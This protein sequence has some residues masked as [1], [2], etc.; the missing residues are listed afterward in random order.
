MGEMT[1]TKYL[2]SV[3]I[4]TGLYGADWK[5]VTPEELAQKAPRV[6]KDADAEAF[7]WEVHV[8]DEAQGGEYPHSVFTHYI[9]I[10]IFTDRG[11]EKYGTVDI[12]YFGR[13]NVSGIAARTIKAD[14]SI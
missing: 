4:A 1:V 2:F 13:T 10:K 14:G 7:L 11:K 6:E 3:L 12:P 8:L 5:A 9:R